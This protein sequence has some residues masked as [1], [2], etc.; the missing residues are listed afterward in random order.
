MNSHRI[1]KI[2]KIPAGVPLGNP[3]KIYSEVPPITYPGIFTGSSLGTSSGNSSKSSC[4]SSSRNSSENLRKILQEFLL[5]SSP[6][7]SSE[8][9]SKISTRNFFLGV[10]TEVFQGVPVGVPGIFP[11][12][13]SD[14]FLEGLLKVINEEFL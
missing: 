14:S 3:P 9:S 11:G 12:S 13:S 4:R 5:G 6:K 7:S 1:P 8:I 10:P 2:P